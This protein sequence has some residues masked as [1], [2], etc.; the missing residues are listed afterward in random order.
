[1]AITSQTTYVEYLHDGIAVDYIINFMYFETTAIKVYSID[2]SAPL[3]PDPWE[4]K[5]LYTIG[6]LVWTGKNLVFRCITQ[7]TSSSA[8]A[9]IENDLVNWELV[10]AYVD[11]TWYAQTELA[12]GSDWSL[13]TTAG[14]IALATG[15]KMPDTV[16]LA[17]AA[18]VPTGH[19][20]K[21]VRTTAATQTA[22]PTDKTIE[23][24]LD[25]L[26]A[27]MQELK[28]EYNTSDNLKV[29][30]DA[31]TAEIAALKPRVTT[32]ENDIDSLQ[33]EQITQ[34]NRITAV[35][36]NKA[37][38]VDLT[39]LEG[40]VT[41]AEGNIT[42]TNALA[43][44]A[45]AKALVNEADMAAIVVDTTGAVDGD[46]LVRD[47]LGVYRPEAKGL[48][49]NHI[50]VPIV[51]VEPAAPAA[52]YVRLYAMGKTVYAKYSNSEVVEILR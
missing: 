33:L 42:T 9:T 52:G 50:D 31:N 21:I 14:G 25:K 22:Q 13:Q 23:V 19:T 1:M 30:V 37:N 20:I 32:A 51:A 24:S 12:V 43:S 41:T 40:R 27:Q 2:K 15:V 18:V 36:N 4:N 5:K 35:E 29:K 26:T 34:N 10:G 16:R 38:Q 3:A 46:V 6:T 8:P 28:A 11:G 39:A 44:S 17:N 47:S 45:M 48:M 7:H 49:R